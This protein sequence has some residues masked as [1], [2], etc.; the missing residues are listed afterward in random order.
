ME[1]KRSLDLPPEVRLFVITGFLGGLTTFSTFSAEVVMQIHEARFLVAFTTAALV[2]TDRLSVPV[3]LVLAAVTGLIA[4]VDGP[5]CTLLGN[6][7]VPREDVPSAI[8]VGSVVHSVGRVVGTASAGLTIGA[9]GLGGAYAANGLSFVCVVAVLPLH[10]RLVPGRHRLRRY[11][12]GS[13]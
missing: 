4:T 3:L 6:D 2:A 9:F 1:R 10:G 7:M 5:A 8:A 12:R 13:L 11:H